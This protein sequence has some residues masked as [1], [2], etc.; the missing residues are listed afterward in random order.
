MK[1]PKVTFLDGLTG[2]TFRLRGAVF[3]VCLGHRPATMKN[4]SG[5]RLL[6]PFAAAMC[7]LAGCAA[8]RPEPLRRP[9]AWFM[10]QRLGGEGRLPV[11]ARSG[12]LERALAR[13]FLDAAPGSWV[14]VGPFNIGGRVTC[15]GVGPT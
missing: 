5:V 7:A 15:L 6:V 10:K 12:A 9:A 14:S 3:E 13:G 8:P 4:A 11:R 1:A 2:E